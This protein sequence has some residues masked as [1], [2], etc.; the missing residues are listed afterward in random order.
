MSAEKQ[1]AVRDASQA[2]NQGRKRWLPIKHKVSA[3]PQKRLPNYDVATS[4]RRNPDS[5][6]LLEPKAESVPKEDW[7]MRAT[8]RTEKYR[9]LAEDSRK[10]GKRR[11]KK[12]RYKTG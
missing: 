2:K 1:E 5:R 4:A 6:A 8:D 3:L 7:P 9:P 11:I 12:L 10:C